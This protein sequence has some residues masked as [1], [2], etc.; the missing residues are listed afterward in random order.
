MYNQ[1]E[2][3]TINNTFALGVSNNC[4]SNIHRYLTDRPLSVY[5]Y[6]E[7]KYDI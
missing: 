3:F 7:E 1:D 2:L 5:M 6:H 4:I